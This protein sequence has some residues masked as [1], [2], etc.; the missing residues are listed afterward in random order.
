[1]HTSIQMISHYDPQGNC[2]LSVYEI[3][4]LGEREMFL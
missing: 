4:F 3:P 1:M 2:T